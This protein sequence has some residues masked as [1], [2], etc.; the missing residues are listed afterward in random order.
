[1]WIC[2]NCGRDNFERAITKEMSEE[3]KIDILREIGQIEDD[4]DL[5][6]GFE[7][8]TLYAPEEVECVHCG[9]KYTTLEGGE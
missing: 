9:S 7:G 6:E 5:P 1:M 2:D 4:E 3:D 8:D